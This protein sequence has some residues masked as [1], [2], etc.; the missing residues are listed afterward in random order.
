MLITKPQPHLVPAGY[1]SSAEPPTGMAPLWA[2]HTKPRAEKK[3]ARYCEGLGVS[4]FLPTS[5]TRHEYANRSVR[6][7][8]LP[9]FPG[10]LFLL[11]EELDRIQLFQSGAIVQ[12][13]P[14]PRPGELY[15]DL[16][17]LWM[18]LVARPSA[19]Q[20]A[21]YQPGMKVLVVKG[22]LKGVTGE[23]VKW[24]KDTERLLIKV[25]LFERAVSV[26]I[27]VAHVRP[28]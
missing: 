20:E 23:L 27:D 5:L 13:M 19:L 16:M 10:Y 18:A 7:H 17:N 1:F 21:Q 15:T 6:T 24:T 9:L 28:L 14:V 12:L 25:H 11:E 26:D 3:L 4:H 2:V 8:W 22:P